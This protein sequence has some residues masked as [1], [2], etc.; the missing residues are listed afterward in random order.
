MGS[1]AVTVSGHPDFQRWR[2]DESS[3]LLWVTGDSGKGK[4]MLL[5]GITEELTKSTSDRGL[6]SF[7]CQG[8]DLRL[9][10]AT[11]ILRGLIYLLLIQQ[12]CL[13]TYLRKKYNH[14]G[15][16][17]FEGANTFYA[18]SEIFTNMVHDARLS[19]VYLII[20]ALD[21]CQ[22]GLTDVLDL[23]SRTASAPMTRIK[24]IVSSQNRSEIEGWLSLSDTSTWLNLELNAKHVS[25]AVDVY[26]VMQYYQTP[27]T[28][29]K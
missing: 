13:L 18:L 21:E 19:A 5:V 9:N 4:T 6:V 28:F 27:D 23:I 20:D 3:R 12:E 29:I 10:N 1:E 7:F 16:Q 15:R 26:N 22:T 17:L 24:W 8:T 14:S 11:S 2:D 25:R